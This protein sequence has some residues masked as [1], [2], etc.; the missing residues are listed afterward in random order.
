MQVKIFT[1]NPFSENTY[2]LYDE[3]KECV[4]IDPGCSNS[5]EEKKLTDFIET[6]ELKPV[7]L[8]NTHGHIDHV[9]GNR[10]VADKYNLK[11]EANKLEEAGILATDSYASMY[12]MHAPRSPK[13]GIYLNEGDT[14]KFGNT[15][16]KVLFTPGHSAGHI[17][18]FNEENKII[19][20]GDVLFRESI[21][22]TDL[23]GG[24]Y[25]TLIKSI[26]EKLFVLEDAITVYPGHGPETTIG[27]E[28][29]YN[30]FLNR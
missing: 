12:G 8:L 21:G 5:A 25:E 6:N 19:I 16:L 2:V 3:T 10:F 22:R 11:L 20:G 24:D 29:L 17:V 30:P 9:L 1:F 23:P 4:I 18:F 7:K 26:K 28:K 13:P 15:S 27:Y 14:V